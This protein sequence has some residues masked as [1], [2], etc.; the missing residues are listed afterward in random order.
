MSERRILAAALDREAYDVIRRDLGTT[1][2]TPQ[3]LQFLELVGGMYERSAKVRAVA[4]EDLEAWIQ[5]KLDNPKHRKAFTDLLGNLPEVDPM[6]VAVLVNEQ[7]AKALRLRLADKL[8][9]GEPYQ[10][11]L[12]ELLEVEAPIISEEDDIEDLSDFETFLADLESTSPKNR[13]RLWPKTMHKRTDGAG[14]GHHILFFGRPGNGK[15]LFAINSSAGHLHDG[16]RVLYL[17]NEEPIGFTRKRLYSRLAR[18]KITDLEKDPA[19]VHAEAMK[20]GL[21]NLVAKNIAGGSVRDVEHWIRR[22]RPDVVV[23]D[24]IRN[25]HTRHGNDSLTRRMEEAAQDF[26]DLLAKYQVLGYSVAQAGAGQDGGND[27]KAFLGKGDIDSSKTGLPGACDLMVGLG[28]TQEMLDS[29][30]RGVSLIKNKLNGE[31]EGD[32]FNV[33]MNILENRID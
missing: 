25:L 15:S 12:D 33:T 2:L 19:R 1:D 8:H 21:A 3:G 5:A 30:I 29:G 18:M 16:Y 4:A 17:G 32:T 6:S 7:R 20:H 9:S 13:L 24:Q 22:V 28:A 10:D 23:M 26:R 11:I 27:N 31:H 14:R